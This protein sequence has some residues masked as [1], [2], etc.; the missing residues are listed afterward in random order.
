[1]RIAIAS[2]KGGTGKTTVA[3][4][5]AFLAS[6][7]EPGVAYLDCDVEEPNGAIFLKPQIKQD[8]P[9][10]AA[11]PKV[12]LAKCT[13]CGLCGKICQYSAILSMGKTVLTFPELC[14]SCAGCWLVCPAGAISQDQRQI[15]RLQAGP[16]GK[17]QFIQGLLDIGQAMSP[18]LIHAL[19]AAA[20]PAELTIVDC[21][22]GTS[23]PVI[24]ALR[25][26]D[27]VL[28]V[29]EPTP[30]GLN[31]LKLAVE[32]VRK[33]KLPFGVLINRADLGDNLTKRYCQRQRI[34]LLAEI[35]DDRQVAEV[36]SRGEMICAG[37]PKYQGLYKILLSKIRERVPIH[38]Q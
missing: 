3:T 8:R 31:D 14:H 36:Y 34:D 15:G 11:V 13:G 25:D 22:P 16:A 32:T 12:D 21:P 5:L 27:Y 29:T 26:V 28:L 33:L 6:H 1:M 10:Y 38:V 17:L 18:P 23:C 20:P 19:K 7:N 2:G 24:E 9:I 37:I 35:P 30:F 4:N